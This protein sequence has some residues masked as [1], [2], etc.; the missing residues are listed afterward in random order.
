MCAKRDATCHVAGVLCQHRAMTN[1]SPWDILSGQLINRPQSLS[2]LWSQIGSI[3]FDGGDQTR[4]VFRGAQDYRWRVRSSIVRRLIA[5]L[6]Q[7]PTEPQI[8]AAEQRLIRVARDWGVGLETSGLADN[9]H[10][11]AMMQHHGVPTRLLD[12]TANPLTA[13][14]FACEPQL[15]DNGLAAQDTDG[16]FI[17]FN[18]TDVQSYDTLQTPSTWG[19]VKDAEGGTLNQALRRSAESRTPFVVEPKLRDAR[20]VA[21]EGLFISSAAPSDA[22]ICDG[23]LDCIYGL[24]ENLPGIASTLAS[25]AGPGAVLGDKISGFGI[26]VLTVPAELKP[27]LRNVLSGT[28]NRSPRSMY[29]D[30]MGLRD[31]LDPKTTQMRVTPPSAASALPVRMQETAAGSEAAEFAPRAVPFQ[32]SEETGTAE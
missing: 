12:V 19:H 26:R 31:A 5:E 14:F 21:Q 13:L 8:V 30:L 10:L 18:V 24:E 25:L 15:D 1:P 16:V 29:P 23:P 7:L 17:A 6:G 11:L 20:M 3:T 32:P 22:D 9:L 2:E 27:T 4:W 28:F